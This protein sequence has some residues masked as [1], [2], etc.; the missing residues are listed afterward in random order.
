MEDKTLQKTKAYFKN[1][2]S[3]LKTFWRDAHDVTTN[4]FL[5]FL[6]ICTALV[7]LSIFIEAM[8]LS[9]PEVTSLTRFRDDIAHCLFTIFIFLLSLYVGRE[10]F[11]HWQIACAIASF[12]LLLDVFYLKYYPP[13]KYT[14]FLDVVL[15]IASVYMAA[16]YAYTS[17]FLIKYLFR[18]LKDIVKNI[19]LTESVGLKRVIECITSIF[20]SISAMIA[21]IYGLLTSFSSLLQYFTE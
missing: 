2:I 9:A 19:L 10:N 13:E 4:S 17:F 14:S 16:F 8:V 1:K 6:S 11:Y 3:L 20:L 5:I 21:G 15:T 18:L 12:I 7:F